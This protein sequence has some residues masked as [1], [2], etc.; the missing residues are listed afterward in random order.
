M[1]IWMRRVVDKEMGLAELL[2][3]NPLD[4]EDCNLGFG[5]RVPTPPHFAPTSSDPQCLWINF[6]LCWPGNHRS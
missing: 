2:W 5:R 4:R 6:F 3:F 1:V